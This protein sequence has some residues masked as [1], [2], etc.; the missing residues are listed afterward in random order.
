MAPNGPFCADVLLINYSLIH[1]LIW[2][3]TGGRHNA[4]DGCGVCVFV[5]CLSPEAVQAQAAGVSPAEPAL[6]FDGRVTAG[7]C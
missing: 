6:Q 1:S 5:V 7:C 2:K 4:N 3:K